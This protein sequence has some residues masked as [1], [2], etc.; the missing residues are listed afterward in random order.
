[1][2]LTVTFLA[3]A[4]AVRSGSP[5]AFGRRDIPATDAMADAHQRL[6]AAGGSTP[7][8]RDWR[9]WPFSSTSPWNY[10]IGK[11]ATYADVS[12]LGNLAVAINYDDRW[13][14][15]V[16]IASR[17]DPVVPVR[18]YRG[19]LWKFLAGPGK[20]CGNTP[21][22][23]LA[24]KEASTPDVLFPANFYSTISSPDSSLWILPPEY[25]PAATSYWRT[26]YLPAGS[27]ASPDTDGLMAVFQP[28]GWVLDLYEGIVLSDNSVIAAMASYVDARGDGTGWWN[29]RRASMLPSFAGLIRKG[30]IASGLIPHALAALMAPAMVT[31]EAVWPAYAFDRNAGYSGT[32]P[33]GAL[34]AIPP[35][36]DLDAL[37]LSRQGK[38][39]ARAAQTYGVYVVDRGGTGGMTFLAEL[40]NREIHWE[41]DARTLASWQELL[42]IKNQLKRVTNNSAQTPGGGGEPLAPM[43]PPFAS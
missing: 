28:N 38:V 35:Q 42:I 6:A 14:A 43:A 21:E 1:V 11:L 13:T 23:E 24:L 26:A 36:V 5:P 18:F 27:C 40:G 34:L 33:I 7:A 41:G 8:T 37:G 16:V 20:V 29:G 30:E 3:F 19:D 9:Y 32:L 17:R 10:P 22:T 31:H 2:S 39:I 4:L 15:S 12:G 25:K